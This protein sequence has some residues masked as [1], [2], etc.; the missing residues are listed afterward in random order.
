MRQALNPKPQ[1][2]NPETETLNPKV[3]AFAVS[4]RRVWEA[5]AL[6]HGFQHHAAW[7]LSAVGFGARA[8][9]YR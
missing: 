8:L 1:T 3:L 6:R 5:V 2:L 4:C 9:W 7:L